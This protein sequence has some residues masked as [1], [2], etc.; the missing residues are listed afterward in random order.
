MDS[1]LHQSMWNPPD[2]MN[3]HREADVLVCLANEN[4]L[5]LRAEPGV[6]TIIS[7]HKHSG[8]KTVDLQWMTPKCYDWATLCR[9]DVNFEE[10]HLSGNRAI[11]T[12]LN[13]PSSQLHEITAKTIPNCT[14][15]D[16]GFYC[17]SLN[18]LLVQTLRTVADAAIPPEEKVN[19]VADQAIDAWTPDLTISQHSRGWWCAKTLNPLKCHANNLRHR[20]PRTGTP[21]DRA[22]YRAAQHQYQ[23]ACTEAK[24]THWRIHLANL[25]TKDLFTA[26]KYTN[27]TPATRTLL[28]L[29]DLNGSLTS[30]PSR[31]A[32]L[33]FQATGGPTIRYDLS[34]ISTLPPHGSFIKTYRTEDIQTTIKK[35]DLGKAP[36]LR[37]YKT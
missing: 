37:S 31:K 10:L 28:P 12:E 1:N 34:H 11:I 26:A 30:D 3:T 36:A 18:S 17:A 23:K 33:P 16:W 14:N 8:Q 13:L 15:T 6:P 19:L 29:R 2:Y 35:L 4:G 7:N 24:T 22:L 21:A 9:T 27:G 5:I 20:A 25:Y 32:E